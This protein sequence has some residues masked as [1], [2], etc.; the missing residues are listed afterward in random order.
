MGQIKGW[1]RSRHHARP[2]TKMAWESDEGDVIAIDYVR[3]SNIPYKII[4]NDRVR[5][6]SS[7]DIAGICNFELVEYPGADNESCLPYL[8]FDMSLNAGQIATTTA[9]IVI[10]PDAPTSWPVGVRVWGED[11]Q[12]PVWGTL[13]TYV[14]NIR[15]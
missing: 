3:S 7:G 5:T 15:S 9:W 14:F 6:L 4:V 1:K 2:T 8:C 13:G 11:E 12:E 10:P